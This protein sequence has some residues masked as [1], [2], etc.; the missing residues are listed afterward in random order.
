MIMRRWDLDGSGMYENRSKKGLVC[1]KDSF[2]L[3]TP[4]GGSKGFEY[5]D[6]G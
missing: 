2:L 1:N 6:T 4:V 5:V 3:L